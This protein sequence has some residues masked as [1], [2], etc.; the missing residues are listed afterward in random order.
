MDFDVIIAGA[1]PAGCVAARDLAGDGF[2]VGLFDCG[3]ENRL[4]KTIILEAET[5]MFARVGVKTPSGDE[6]PYH[7]R[8]VHVASRRFKPGFTIEDTSKTVGMYLDKFVSRLLADAR[9]SGAMFF[10]KHRAISPISAN[11]KVTGAVFDLAGSK[12][13]VKSRL[14]IDA[15]GFQ[16]ALV[17]RLDPEMGIDFIEDKNDEVVAENYMHDI[18]A[19]EA[20][21]AVRNGIAHDEEVF[22]RLGFAGPYSTE[23]SFL[24][25]KNRHAYVLIGLKAGF[26][27]PPIGKLM[28]DFKNRMGYFRERLHGGGGS[29]RIR[30]SID[31]L[32][33][34]G[35]MVIGEAACQV[36]PVHGSGVAS[37][38][39]AGHLAAEAASGALKR[40][41][42]TQE[43]LWKYSWEYQHDRGGTLAALDVSRL[44][45]ESFTEEKVESMVENG[46]MAAEDMYNSLIPAA[47]SM[48]LGSLPKRITGL[49]KNPDLIMPIAKMGIRTLSVLSHYK[50]YPRQYD[51]HEFKKWKK[52]KTELFAPLYRKTGGMGQGV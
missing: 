39:W 32:A 19:A 1:G 23:Y 41:E 24:S 10:E 15:T 40:G 6:I 45:V 8:A 33:A 42:P 35:F 48:S 3:T 51:A 31:K 14:V 28:D 12:Q 34:N 25:L 7:A 16:A 49:L 17:K 5:P 26:M 50:K 47:V 44:T 18:D 27:G 20:E 43:A 46:V 29:I 11:G 13:E 38:L 22:S 52:T 21:K 36:V 4:A 9:A 2:R 30:H 37:A